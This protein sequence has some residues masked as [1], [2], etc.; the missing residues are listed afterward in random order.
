MAAIQFP[1]P[2]PVPVFL[3][4]NNTRQEPTIAT[5]YVNETVS[6]STGASVGVG[7]STGFAIVIA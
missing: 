1:L 6:V 5:V 2:G 4:S 3:N 7:T